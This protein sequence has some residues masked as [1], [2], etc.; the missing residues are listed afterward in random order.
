MAAG[1]ET[2]SNPVPKYVVGEKVL[3]Y[4]PDPNKARVL[5]ESKVLE[6]DIT[7]DDKGK[8]VPEYFI[9]FNGWNRSWDRWVVEDQVMKDSESNRAFMIKLHDQA[10]KARKKKRRLTQNS[11]SKDS[12]GAN[13]SETKSSVSETAENPELPKIEIEIPSQLKLKL[14][15]DCY[16]IKRKKKLVQLPRT[17]NVGQILNEYFAHY[18]NFY[19][20]QSFNLI[21]EVMDGLRIYFDFTL[22]TLLLY[23]FEREQY[24]TVMKLTPGHEEVAKEGHNGTTYGK[25]QAED[26]YGVVSSSTESSPVKQESG[27]KFASPTEPKEEVKQQRLLRRRALRHTPALT[28]ASQSAT[29]SST[30]SFPET[31]APLSKRRAVEIEDIHPNSPEAPLPANAFPTSP[32]PSSLSVHSHVMPSQVYGPE[33]FLRLFVKLPG[34]LARTD[35]P[36]SHLCVLLEQINTFLK[37]LAEKSTVLFTEDAYYNSLV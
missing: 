27:N 16:F 5:Y 21:K 1:R 6:V 12:D 22:P 17:P 14:E 7:R 23:N 18:M 36:E 37:Y 13:K 32:I 26:K 28:E 31:N 29:V 15:D 10:L 19:P 30:S 25:T 3:C 11:E 4:E 34:L 2:R 9:H 8:R 20:G 35:M 33:H 24:H